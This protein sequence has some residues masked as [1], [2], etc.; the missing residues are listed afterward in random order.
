MLRWLPFRAPAFERVKVAFLA[1]RT[2][3]TLAWIII[4]LSLV[5]VW[6]GT[7][8]LFAWAVGWSGGAP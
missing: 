7:A 1:M 3:V 5:L 6:V 4:M 8:R 2:N